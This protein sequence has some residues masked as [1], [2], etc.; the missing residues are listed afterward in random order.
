MSASAPADSARKSELGGA[1][2]YAPETA[3][4]IGIGPGARVALGD[5]AEDHLQGRGPP[6]EPA[7][8]ADGISPDQAD[9]AAGPMQVPQQRPGGVAVLKEAAVILR[10]GIPA[11][12]RRVLACSCADCRDAAAH[13]AE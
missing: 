6:G 13:R 4:C 11:G 5:D 3:L 8:G 10:R 9:A 12:L 1:Q 7:A 2:D